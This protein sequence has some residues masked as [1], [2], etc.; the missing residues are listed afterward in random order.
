MKDESVSANKKKSLTQRAL[1]FLGHIFSS[2]LKTVG[3][4]LVI[5]IVFG[6]LGEFI[7]GP[8]SEGAGHEIYL[9]GKGQD[10]IVVVPL[11]GVIVN[12][13]DPFS[14]SVDTITPEKVAKILHKIGED[15][16]VK[17]VILDID[18][19][20]GSA[21]ASDR[22]YQSVQSFKS[23]SKKPV[24][25]VMAD[26]VA[27][28]GYYIAA[29]SDKIVANPSTITGSIGVIA[30]NLK[31]Q[32]LF[33][34][35]GIKE[36]VYKKGKYKDILSSTRDTTEEE[37][38]IID[39]ILDDAYNQFLD[40]VSQGRK[41]ELQKVKDIAGGKIYSGIGA[42]EVGLVDELGNLEEGVALAKQ[43]AGLKQARVVRIE[44]AN[45]F[46]QFFSGFSLK[47]FFPSLET[48]S[49]PRVWYMMK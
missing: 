44:T 39:N 1:G 37:R 5:V 33:D 7:S 34:K 32:G 49:L 20:G 2:G 11:R 21:V 38:A 19:P 35:L 46:N 12:A 3:S 42:K 45:F 8:L 4:F 24:L 23:N 10:K 18:S 9:S 16:T 28:G 30:T 14:G 13:V 17:A 43:L 47:R 26:V 31:V 41:L 36:E 48:P 40:R 27:S 25:S 15:K 6:L 29:A 22:I